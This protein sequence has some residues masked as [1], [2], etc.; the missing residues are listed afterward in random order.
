MEKEIWKAVLGFEGYYVVSNRG[1]IKSFSKTVS[2]GTNK[3]FIPGRTMKSHPSASGY[4]VIK[5]SKQH[6]PR[7]RFVHA[8]VLEAFVGPCPPDK[9]CCR[10]LDGNKQN[11]HLSNLC[12][13]TPKENSEDMIKHGR[14]LKGSKQAHSKLTESDIPGIHQHYKNG[15]TCEQIGKIYGVTAANIKYVIQGNTWTHCQPEDKAKPR[16]SGFQPGN[17]IMGKLDE[18]RKTRIKMLWQ[19]GTGYAEIAK[20]IGVSYCTV[21]NFLNGKSY[22]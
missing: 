3:R 12:W 15:L 20:T 1:N 21:W 17:R 10:H 7:L 14:Y 19:G 16:P 6:K 4:Q 22:R 13:G 18:S 11:N 5:L 8:L 9:H 2:I